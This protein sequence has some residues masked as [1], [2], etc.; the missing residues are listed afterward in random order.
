MAALQKIDKEL[1]SALETLE[2]EKAS[3]LKDLDSQVNEN[4]NQACV[5]FKS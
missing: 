1:N 5:R 2:K 3:A 4:F